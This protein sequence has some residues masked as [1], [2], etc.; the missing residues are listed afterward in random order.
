MIRSNDYGA[1]Y[2]GSEDTGES[3]NYTYEYTNDL[4]RT[5][6]GIVER[7]GK[8][9]EWSLYYDG[10]FIDSGNNCFSI[11]DCKHQMDNIIDNME[12]QY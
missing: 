11:D 1:R 3:D 10:S 2:L 9:Y 7:V 6:R 5:Y 8:Y 12:G 4:N